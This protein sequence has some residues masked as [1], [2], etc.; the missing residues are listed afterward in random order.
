MDITPAK[1]RGAMDSAAESGT[2]TASVTLRD[3]REDDL[4]AVIALDARV[5]GLEK[6]RYWRELY[7]RRGRELPFLVAEIAGPDGAARLAGF[8][9]GEVRAWEFG[10][11]PCGWVFALTV[12]PELRL[13]G[14]GSR[15]MDAIAERF[16]AAGVKRMRTMLA[17]DNHLLMAFFRSHGM[18][19]GPYIELEKELD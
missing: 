18:M 3:G 12:D 9:I 15:L 19:A 16:R 7:S 5:T 11:P 4:P 6:E 17:R 10:S 14:I 13:G 2:E 8:S 1:E